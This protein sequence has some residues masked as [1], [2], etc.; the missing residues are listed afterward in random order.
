MVVTVDGLCLGLDGGNRGWALLR[1]GSGT[2]LDDFAL[3]WIRR[4]IGRLCLGLDQ[5]QNWMTLLWIGSGTGLDDF[6]LGWNKGR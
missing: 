4:R 1:V 3:D 5:A 6:A 2:G